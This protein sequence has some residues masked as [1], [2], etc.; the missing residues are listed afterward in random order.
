MKQFKEQL[1]AEKNV[2]S[3][4]ETL[5]S[6]F[7]SQ[8]NRKSNLQEYEYKDHKDPFSLNQAYS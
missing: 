7:S 2:N 4:K 6:K 3:L 5:L 1:I 8:N